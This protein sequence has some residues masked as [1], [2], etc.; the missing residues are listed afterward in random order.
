MRRVRG[1][2]SRSLPTNPPLGQKT[3]KP[4]HHPRCSE[5][6]RLAVDPNHPP[7]GTIT[8]NAN[9]TPGILDVPPFTASGTATSFFDVF[10]DVN[11]GGQTL[12]PAT[13]LHLTST[14]RH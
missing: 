3:R 2:A 14:I 5:G 12:T 13:P 6:A 4:K 10:F 7:V 8:E 9:N 1:G 11:I